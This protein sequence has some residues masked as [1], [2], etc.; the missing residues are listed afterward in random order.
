MKPGAGLDEAS[1]DLVII[2]AAHGAERATAVAVI[3]NTCRLLALS[4]PVMLLS[5]D[6]QATNRPAS[7]ATYRI[8]SALLALCVRN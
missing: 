3:E 2:K 5:E 7:G 6:M 8:L 1:V 4:G